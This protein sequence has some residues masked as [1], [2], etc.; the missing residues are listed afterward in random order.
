MWG[1]RRAHPHFRLCD[2]LLISCMRHGRDDL[3]LPVVVVV[4]L[5]VLI[6]PLL[7]T[8]PPIHLLEMSMGDVSTKPLARILSSVI[9]GISIHD[10]C[11]IRRS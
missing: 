4:V 7:N 1:A 8:P 5:S 3:L 10:C 2:E 11:C 9:G 6:D